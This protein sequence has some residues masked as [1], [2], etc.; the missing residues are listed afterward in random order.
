MDSK[1]YL[2]WLYAVLWMCLIFWFS[3]QPASISSEMSGGILRGLVE[4][5]GKIISVSEGQVAMLH[6]LIRKLAHLSIYTVLGLLLY[7][8][9]M[10]TSNMSRYRYFELG[11]RAFIIGMFYAMTDE[12]HQ[13]F[14][15]GRSC[16]FRDVL[17][18]SFGVLIGILIYY[19]SRKRKL[20][21]L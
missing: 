8:A 1:K 2:S 18:D 20:K 15:I 11:K 10:A 7:N 19:N 3:H 13:L 4:F 9:L 17:I 6:K 21:Y 5:I 16:E 12:L 14:V